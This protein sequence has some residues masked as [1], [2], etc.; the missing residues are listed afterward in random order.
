MRNNGIQDT[1]CAFVAVIFVLA[2]IA[3]EVLVGLKRIDLTQ[4]ITSYIDMAAS[5][6]SVETAY[7]NLLIAVKNAEDRG[8]TDGYTSALWRTQEESIGEWYKNLKSSLS[9][10]E[11]VNGRPAYESKLV[12]DR[13]QS[14][15][16]RY[17]QY[18]NTQRYTP[19]GLAFYPHNLLWGLLRIIAPLILMFALLVGLDNLYYL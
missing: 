19:A 9:E 13:V 7:D 16:S 18:S 4:N 8:L 1:I 12:L 5:S 2:A 14:S 15:L 17:E 10:L 11:A 6:S 3:V